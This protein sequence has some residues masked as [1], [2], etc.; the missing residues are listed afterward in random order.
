MQL[1]IRHSF[2]VEDGLKDALA[3]MKSQGGTTFSSVTD[4]AQFWEW[5]MTALVPS[6]YKAKQYNGETMN[7]YEKNYIASF[8]RANLG[9]LA[10]LHIGAYAV[11]TRPCPC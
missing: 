5:M 7:P 1:K 6:V 10:M 8:N 2:D 3:G 4:P 11:T 9:K